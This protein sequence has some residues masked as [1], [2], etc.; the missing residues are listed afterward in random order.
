MVSPSKNP[1]GN[2]VIQSLQL[3]S[4]HE[5]FRD[6]MFSFGLG[7]HVCHPSKVF[8]TASA[9]RIYE[10]DIE[11]CCRYCVFPGDMSMFRVRNPSLNGL[12]TGTRSVLMVTWARP[13]S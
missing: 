12:T 9:H 6:Q 4:M 1:L 3:N 7:I 2:Q 10:Y 13:R 8:I 11:K 5:Q